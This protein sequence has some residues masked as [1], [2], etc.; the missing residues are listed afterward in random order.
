M[1]DVVPYDV[2]NDHGGKED[3]ERRK[4]KIE[5]AVALCESSYKLL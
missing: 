1:T 4:N 5:Y 3:A 2:H